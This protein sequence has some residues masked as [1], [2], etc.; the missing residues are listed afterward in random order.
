MDDKV[1]VDIQKYFID[2]VVF[3]RL[4]SFVFDQ[5]YVLQR[6]F[7]ADTRDKNFSPAVRRFTHIGKETQNVFARFVYISNSMAM[8]N[9]DLFKWKISI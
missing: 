4:F 3:K 2:D 7:V 1:L 5:E 9:N 8:I 6:L